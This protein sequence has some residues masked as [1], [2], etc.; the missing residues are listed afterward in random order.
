MQHQE[1]N[2]KQ[3]TLSVIK[4]DNDILIGFDNQKLRHRSVFNCL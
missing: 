1:L 2:L 3:K 4:I